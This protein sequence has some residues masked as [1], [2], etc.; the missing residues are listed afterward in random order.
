MKDLNMQSENTLTEAARDALDGFANGPASQAADDVAR[1]FEQA[2]DR[3]ANSLEKAAQTGEFSFNALAESITRDFA[4]LAIDQLIT[5]P[6]EGFVGS[7]TGAITGALGGASGRNTV[8]VNVSGAAQ[9]TGS[10]AQPSQ[11][12]MANRIASVVARSGG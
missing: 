3:I 4:K 1:A 11:R 9:T 5:A 2:G 12:Q 6:L 8:T 10:G 7:L